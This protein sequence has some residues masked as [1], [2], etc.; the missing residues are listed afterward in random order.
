MDT[1]DRLAVLW[2]NIGSV[3]CP[4]SAI[5]RNCTQWLRAVPGAMPAPIALSYG[6]QDFLGNGVT[7]GSNHAASIWSWGMATHLS[8]IFLSQIPRSLGVQR[9]YIINEN[10]WLARNALTVQF[11][12]LFLGL[13]LR[14]LLTNSDRLLL[15][16]FLSLTILAAVTVGFLF[17]GKTWCNYFCPMAPVQMVYSEPSGLLGSKA[18]TAPPKT[19]TQSMCRTVG[20]KGRKKCLRC[21]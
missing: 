21:L 6:R 17:A 16:I 19:I 20:K 14:L 7:A 3:D 4:R 12:L 8:T 13:N 2:S 5:C 10:S 1:V 9:Q 15:G 11:C 18:H